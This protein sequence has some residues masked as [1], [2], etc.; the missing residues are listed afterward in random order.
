MITMLVGIT[1]YGFLVNS[2][3]S[4]LSNLDTLNA[5]KKAKIE[6]IQVSLRLLAQQFAIGPDLYCRFVL[7]LADY[8]KYDILSCRRCGCCDLYA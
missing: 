8:T 7:I 3:G 4:I 6:K 2:I 1:V 5:H